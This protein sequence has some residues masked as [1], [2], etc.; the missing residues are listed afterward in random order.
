MYKTYTVRL[1]PDLKQEELMYKHVNACRFMWNYM[2]ELQNSRYK[3]GRK[4]LSAFD[5]MNEITFMKKQ[6]EFEWLKEVSNHSLQNICKDLDKAFKMFFNKTHGKPKYKSKK[7]NNISFPIRQDKNA[8]YFVNENYIQIPKLKNVKYKTNYN[9]TRETKLLNP[10]IQYIKSSKKWILTFAIECDSQTPKLSNESMGIDLGVKE[11]A[12]V[13]FGDR[14]IIFHNINKSKRMRQLERKKKHIKKT[15]SRKY[16]TF[17]GK[18]T[19]DKGEHREKSK[20]IEEYEQIL[21]EI[22]YKIANIRHNHIHQITRQLINM[23]PKRV[24]MEDLNV[25]GMKK[26][27]HLS[28]AISEQNFYFFIQ[29]MKYKCEEYGIE[30][31]RADRYYPSSK[32]CSNC[33]HKKVDLKLSDRIYICP[34]CGLEIDRDYN[35]A[36]NLKNYNK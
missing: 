30:F 6:C 9:F 19:M 2:L 5:M 24:V 16:K 27:K 29:C 25:S 11:Q 35:A 18:G 32:I 33:G 34:V 26:N 1:L 13:A 4:S 22:E 12:I 17:N 20:S 7:K 31:I 21:R 3:H 23:L 15:I 28:K 14:K 10:R 36:I 8:T